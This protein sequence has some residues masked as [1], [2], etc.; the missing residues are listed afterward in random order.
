M[1]SLPEVVFDHKAH[2][3]GDE[4]IL[5]HGYEITYVKQKIGEKLMKRTCIVKTGA[6]CD[7]I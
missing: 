7:E 3:H 1:D 5:I 4:Q 6:N 2:R